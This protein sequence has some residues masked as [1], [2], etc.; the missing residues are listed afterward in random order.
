MISFKNYITESKNLH[1]TH[2]EDAIIDGGVKGARNAIEYLRELRSM[3]SGSSSKPMNISVKWDGAPA[4]FAGIDP[5]DGKFFVAKK[6]VF[7]KTPKLYK[8]HDDI[9]ADTVGKAEL[10]SKLKIA[11]DEFSKLG[12]KGV[13]QGDFLYEKSDIKKTK[14]NGESYITFHPNT[15]VYAIPAKSELA[16]RILASKVG[17]VWHTV[18]RGSS[19]ESMS[20]S[21]GEEIASGLNTVK[22]A[23]SVDAVFKDQSGAASFTAADTEEFNNHLSAIG[24]IF[25]TVPKRVFDGISGQEDLNMRTNTYINTK[26]REGQRVGN[27]KA[28]VKGLQKYLNDYFDGEIKS[29]KTDKGKG[30]WQ[31]KKDKAMSFFTDNKA[32]DIENLFLMY[33]HIVDAKHM[34]V[35]QLNNVQGLET[36]LKTKK[37]FEVTGQEGFVAIDHMGKNALKLVDR[38]EFS[39]ANFSP[40]YIKGWQK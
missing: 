9:D 24:R 26:V 22:T 14:I 27:P 30:T 1:M 31:A 29:K 36:F 4:V 7:N 16:R 33:N 21:F 12:I 23:W 20:A 2:L 19:L 13:V 6:G 38:L 11:L 8:T 32:K 3:L 10:N 5:S 18:Y 35:K 17:V 25:K 37:G 40:E 39:K 34:V 15:I 28:F